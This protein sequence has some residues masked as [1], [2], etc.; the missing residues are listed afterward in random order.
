MQRVALTCFLGEGLLIS[1]LRLFTAKCSSE[2]ISRLR[3]DIPL[4][5]EPQPLCSYPS[6]A[7]QGK[8]LFSIKLQEPA[9]W[10]L[11]P[12]AASSPS[13]E[14][15]F[16]SPKNSEP[17]QRRQ[18][19]NG[20]LCPKGPCAFPVRERDR[21]SPPEVPGIHSTEEQPPEATVWLDANPPSVYV[22]TLLLRLRT[23]F[24]LSLERSRTHAKPT[25]T[26]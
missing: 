9:V 23:H 13:R 18:P 5:P 24:Q 12:R 25:Q 1:F 4:L 7:L 2:T 22:P 15:P 10:S 3:E 17:F 16:S 21:V 20:F 26:L 11:I 8:P 19:L 14:L 6:L